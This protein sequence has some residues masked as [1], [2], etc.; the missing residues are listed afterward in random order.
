MSETALANAV[1]EIK[2]QVIVVI[3]AWSHGNDVAE[4]QRQQAVDR[5][6]DATSQ[7]RYLFLLEGRGFRKSM[8]SRVEFLLGIECALD[9]FQ[10]ARE[11]AWLWQNR[12]SSLAAIRCFFRSAGASKHD[13]VQILPD[14]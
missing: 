2:N 4:F 10:Q 11:D 12:P 5:R 7:D 9:H 13:Y 3:R 6:R 1:V 14:S 8:S